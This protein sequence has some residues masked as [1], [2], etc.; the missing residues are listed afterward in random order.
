MPEHNTQAERLI[1]HLRERVG[2]ALNDATVCV[3]GG[4]G[5]IGGHLCDALVSLGARVTIIDDLSNSDT[6]HIGSLI[7]QAPELVRFVQGSILDPK[8]LDEAMDGASRVFHLAALG[9]V[10]K[11]V[12]QPDRTWL[13]NATGTMRVLQA[14][15]RAGASRLIYSASSSAYGNN[16]ALPKREDM[17]PEPESPYAAAKFAGESL[18]RS[19]A[20]CY[21]IDTISLRY[22]NIFGTRQAAD[23]AY[24]AVI[25]AF[26]RRWVDEQAPTI[27]GDG[28]QTRDFTHVSNA[29]LAN[30]LAGASDTALDGTVV[31]IGA[32]VRTSVNGLASK[33]QSRMG[34][35]GLHPE[36]APER[37][38]EVRDSVANIDRARELIGYEPITN[39]EDGL[40]TTVDWYK[41]ALRE[42]RE[43]AA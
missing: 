2:G 18:C 30:L 25:P 6:R 19:W 5:F 4:A 28:E 43:G 17:A 12:E 42:E 34:V 29:V 41:Q 23:S 15:Q 11:S 31:N 10:P 13:V 22:F 39:L 14:A 33:I 38:G 24:A 3:T 36:H 27:F 9:S 1:S 16:P 32:G 26:I 20:K 35:E 40:A 7:D 21:G 8:A 37:V